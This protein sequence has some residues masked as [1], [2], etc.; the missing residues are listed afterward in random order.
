MPYIEYQ[1]SGTFLG[2]DVPQSER[3]ATPLVG[4]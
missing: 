1:G 3:L 2:E 4:K